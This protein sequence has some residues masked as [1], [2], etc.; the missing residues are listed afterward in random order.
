[1]IRI[2]KQQTAE[3]KLNKIAKLMTYKWC[4]LLSITQI[5]HEK[6]NYYIPFQESFK[7]SYFHYQVLIRSMSSRPFFLQ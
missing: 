5:L 1:M 3:S 4:F 7:S 2:K 6:E